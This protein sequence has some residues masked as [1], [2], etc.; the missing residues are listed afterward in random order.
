MLTDFL[1]EDGKLKLRPETKSQAALDRVIGLGKPQKVIDMFT[2]MVNLGIAWDW[3]ENYIYHLNDVDSWEKWIAPEPELDE[4]G[5]TLPTETKPEK[6]V[7]PVRGGDIADTG[8][9]R[10]LFK[11]DREALVEKLT[12]EHDGMVFDANE[13]SQDRMARAAIVMD[14]AEITTWV[15]ADNSVVNVTKLQLIT[16]LRLS[17]QKQTEVWTM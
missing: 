9:A 6:P 12:V 10:T 3:C 14:D 17:G 13:V 11:A 16:V 1:D 4:E 5:N 2:A 7:V 15:L 8:Y